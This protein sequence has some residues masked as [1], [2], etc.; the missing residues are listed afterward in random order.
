MVN[1]RL[2]L[3]VLF[4]SISL[5]SLAKETGGGSANSCILKDECLITE[6]FRDE[7]TVYEIRVVYDLRGGTLHIPANSTISF[8]GGA[9][10]NGTVVGDNTTIEAPAV[11]IFGSDVSVSGTWNVKEAYPEWFGAKGDMIS[12]DREAIQKAV[13]F[14]KTIILNGNYLV[15]NAPFDW[16]GY[17]DKPDDESSYY[18]DVLSQKA[19]INK[20]ALTPL[21]IPSKR[22]IVL[23]GTIKA[24]SPLGD[25]IQI[26][27]NDVMICGSGSIEGC[28]LVSTINTHYT[29]KDA[30]WY[31]SLIHVEGKRNTICG[32][33]IK[34]PTTCGVLITDYNSSYNVIKNCIIGGG[35]KRHTDKSTSSTFTKLFGVLDRGTRN[36][37]EGNT[38]K[39]IEGRSLYTALFSDYETTNVP[40][41]VSDRNTVHTFFRNNDI[42]GCLE[43]AVYSYA[44][45]NVIEGNRISDCD[46]AALQLFHGY[47]RVLNNIISVAVPTQTTFNLGIYC[48]GEHQ[49]IKNNTIKNTTG[50]GIRIQGYYNGS[51]DYCVVEGNY[52]EQNLNGVVSV[53]DNRPYPAISVENSAFRDNKLIIDHISI[54]DN[55]VLCSGNGK[56]RT[57]SRGILSVSGDPKSTFKKIDIC[58]N[59]II[60]STI[61]NEIAVVLNQISKGTRVNIE[62]NTIISTTVPKAISGDGSIIVV[63][64]STVNCQNNIIRHL[65]TVNGITNSGVAFYVQNVENFLFSGNTVVAKCNNNY[66]WFSGQDSNISIS[67]DNNINGLSS[68]MKLT[69]PQGQDA[70][71]F[72]MPVFGSMGEKWRLKV[73]PKNRYT[74]KMEKSDPVSIE[75]LDVNRIMLRHSSVPKKELIYWAVAEYMM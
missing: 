24:F 28:G 27:G 65:G 45:G 56:T 48:S 44:K 22:T 37:V 25:L 23:R 17:P 20:T 71:S 36:I 62:G 11:D 30:S 69:I 38:F 60:G 34:D 63:N 57:V 66:Q 54:K 42:I 31:A 67:H 43:H 7:N 33:T 32:I 26:I 73:V 1:I 39:E 74:K 19:K 64:V 9:I 15:K 35:L 53:S 18:L 61:N 16:A 59:S 2:S 12:D 13:N 50:Y 21:I 6:Q 51:C 40:A 29:T 75:H 8:D 46:G 55:K 5:A 47:N 14:G 10:C 4:A 72:N 49:E 41:R 52:I 58:G 3:I 70:I 68:A